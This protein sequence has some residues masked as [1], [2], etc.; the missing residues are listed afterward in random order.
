M[1]FDGY[2][3]SLNAADRVNIIAFGFKRHPRQLAWAELKKRAGLLKKIHDLPFED[4]IAGL[5]K[6]NPHTQAV[7]KLRSALAE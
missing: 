1:S 4:F 3:A 7:L 2:V 5:K 6:L